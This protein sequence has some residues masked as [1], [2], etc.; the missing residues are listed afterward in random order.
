MVDIYRILRPLPGEPPSS[1]VPEALR[2]ALPSVKMLLQ[3][4]DELV[5]ESPRDAAEDVKSV[6]VSRMESA[7]TLSVPLKA[8]ASIAENWFEGK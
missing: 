6:I 5:F 4:H 7:M 3:I 1:S 2:P 8:D